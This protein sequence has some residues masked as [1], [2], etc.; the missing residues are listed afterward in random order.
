[1]RWTHNLPQFTAWRD[2]WLQHS[3]G[4]PNKAWQFLEL[5]RWSWEFRLAN[6]ARISKVDHQ[7][8]ESWRE[9]E[10]EGEENRE[11]EIH[12][13]FWRS[14]GAS[15]WVFSWVLSSTHVWGNYLHPGRE[16]PAKSN[17]WHSHRAGNSSYSPQPKW[18]NFLTHWA[19]GWVFRKVLPHYWAKLA[20]KV[21][22]LL[23]IPV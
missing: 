14:A 15:P 17:Y 8:G 2:S 1:M 11:R 22:L 23:P 7:R 10:G 3:Q 16:T 12:R 19:S 5:K 13:V 21:A 18:K 20:L 9:G 6:T 4:N